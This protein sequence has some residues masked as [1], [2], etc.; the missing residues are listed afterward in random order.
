MS[1][2]PLLQISKLT[3][4]VPDR[5]LYRDL[6][7]SV[8]RGETVALVGG[9]GSGKSTLL[10]MV[11]AAVEGSI[12]AALDF[13]VTVNGSLFLS[14]GVS[15][16]SL[17]QTFTASSREALSEGQ[18]QKQ[19][20][21]KL[22][23]RGADL[24]LFDEPTNYLDIAGIVA[25]EDAILD[26]MHKDR[27]VVLVSHDR[28]LINN[29][30]LRTV[31][32]T[33]HGVYQT[34]GGYASAQSLAQASFEAKQSEAKNIRIKIGRLQEE[35]RRRMNWSAQKEKSKKGA[36][37]EKPHIAKMAA[38]MASRAKAAQKMAEKEIE[39]LQAAKPF[40]PKQVMLRLPQYQVRRRTVFSLENVSF[41]YNRDSE[42]NILSEV[43]LAADTNERICL[44]GANGAGKSTLL[45]LITGDL[46][47]TVGR[48]RRNENVKVRTL[49]QGLRGF[50]AGPT[51]LDDF[52]EV[53]ADE[54]TV[55]TQLGGV[56][57]RGEKARQSVDTLSPG[58]LARAALVKCMLQGAEFLLFDEPTSHLD[59][60]SVEVLERAL[61]EFPG[62]YLIVSHDRAF[63]E[64][65]ADQL[66]VIEEGRLKMA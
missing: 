65:A 16:A 39:K 57:I 55:R 7:F 14:P 62:G 38:K 63:V 26:L 36:G 43:S 58:E 9:N 45:K 61:R 19:A 41:A 6:S 13:E 66:Y 32:L 60:E 3:V 33:P 50:F 46:D 28:A 64:Q 12:H 40:V 1:H 20:I 47:P 44:M 59:I 34:K 49:P 10:K 56:M 31:Y 25:F 27:G 22:L 21:A 29:L 54:A 4:E 24:F 17:P 15:V 11:E 35:A 42:R 53:I 30:A 18:R 37:N 2:Q 51:L 52:A 23:E 8:G 5:T 48:A